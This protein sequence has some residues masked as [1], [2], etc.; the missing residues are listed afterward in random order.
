LFTQK[1]GYQAEDAIEAV[2][3]RDHSNQPSGSISYGGWTKLGVPGGPAFRLKPDIFNTW[4]HRFAEIKPLSP[5]G[6][7]KA[8][9]QFGVYTA[10]FAPFGYF[11]DIGWSPSTHYAVA[12]TRSI[13]FFN[14]GGIIFYTSA[15]DAAEDLLLL[16][17]YAAVK[18]FVRTP[19]GQRI[20]SSSLEA[21]GERIAG[22]VNV[23]V[24][25]GQLELETNLEVGLITD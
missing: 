13:F 20:I 19:A 2:Y 9:I 25:G 4:T 23:G 5:S 17:T 18:A 7:I 21:I 11:P 3:D 16:T 12:G 8:G 24:K 10:V 6:I 15:T 22:L 1:E 14:A